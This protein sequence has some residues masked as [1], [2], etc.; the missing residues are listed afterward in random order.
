MKVKDIR[1][2]VD[3]LYYNEA[4][5]VDIVDGD[6]IVLDIDLGYST[7]NRGQHCRLVG[8]NTPETR[9]VE[10]PLGLIAAEYVFELIPPGS[11]LLIQSYKDKEDSFGR[12]LVDVYVF[13]DNQFLKGAQLSFT[14]LNRKLINEGYAV[15]WDGRGSRPKFDVKKECPL[16]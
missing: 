16:K 9:G 12:Y 7:W 5:V 10:R 4:D 2:L 3:K 13:E 1:E 14:H 6:T 11:P 8:I 15:E